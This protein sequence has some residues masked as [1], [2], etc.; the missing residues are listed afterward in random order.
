MEKL[1]SADTLLKQAGESLQAVYDAGQRAVDSEKLVQVLRGE[2]ANQQAALINSNQQVVSLQEEAARSLL[3]ISMLQGEKDRTNQHIESLEGD[4]FQLRENLMA[5]E[6]CIRAFN[7]HIT[8]DKVGLAL[9]GICDA[10]KYPL[11]H[12]S[13]FR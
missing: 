2:L 4:N 9:G 12:L 13:C 11:S 8:D 10:E 6:S 3:Q 5:A 7:R 1:Y